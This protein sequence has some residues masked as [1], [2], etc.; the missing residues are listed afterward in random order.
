MLQRMLVERIENRI[1]VGIVMFVGI[2]LLVGWT[3]IKENARMASFEQ[4]FEARA[5][6]R[7][8]KLYSANCSTCHGNDGRG[9][10]GRAPGLNNPHLFGFDYYAEPKAAL[11][12][13][14]TPIIALQN[15]VNTQN[16]LI[17]ALGTEQAGLESEQMM[18]ATE[19]QG[20]DEAR[21]AEID[22]R[23]AAIAARLAEIADAV[24]AAEAARD[25]AQTG[26]DTYIA[27][28]QEAY[29]AI[30][31]RIQEIDDQL[32]NATLNG[33][34][35]RETLNRNPGWFDRMNQA[36]W[37]ST[38]ESY[39]TTTLIHGRTQT[40]GMW[41][42]NIMAA[43]SQRAGG[44]LR[45]DQIADLVSYIRNWDK[46][47]AWTI[48]DALLVAQFAQVPGAGGG[49]QITGEPAGTNVTA[50]VNELATLTGDPARGEQIYNNRA[51]SQLGE[52]LGC[53]GCHAGG[54]Q[55][56]ATE[57]QWEN[58]PAARLTLPQ[59]AGYT[60]EQYMVESIVLPAAYI[61][62]GYESGGMPANFGERMSVQD[63]A[64]ILEYVKSY[65]PDYVPPAGGGEAPPADEASAS[66]GS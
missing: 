21:T 19:L 32:L 5:I 9:I 49:G 6:E 61:V 30:A 13:L 43:W 25:T 17:A 55:A 10:N 29:D 52:R 7:G 59:F 26:I 23:Q 35:D 12:N 50:I 62:P 65:N 57:D 16:S 44:P 8:A 63:I 11:A 38:L 56:P 36:N 27:E 66:T 20:A 51:F 42:G 15:E 39:L 54:A 24:A 2:M 28:N 37:G 18:L 41:G 34:P 60:F 53:S 58:V 31:A 4:Q 40:A 64:D 46:G 47:N 14:E 3:A 1:L 33:Y 45:D 48:E 22:A